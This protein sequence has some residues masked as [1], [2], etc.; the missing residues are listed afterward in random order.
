[1][2]G[3]DSGMP[4]V[5]G[6]PG[7]PRGAAWPSIAA[8]TASAPLR[9]LFAP[10]L[11]LTGVAILAWDYA[12][13]PA[14]P[15]DHV[16]YWLGFGCVYAG[17]VALGALGRPTS[18]RQLVALA[19]LGAVMWLPYYLRSPDRLVFVDELYHRDV[20]ARILDTG[21]AIGLPVTLYPLP[22]NF[23]GLESLTIAVMGATGLGLD[24][25][26]RVVTLAI[27]ATIPC[28]AYLVARGVGLGARGAFVAALVYASN[29]SFAF[30]HSVF[31][32]ETLGVLQFLAVWALVAWYR[33]APADGP[34]P[35]RRR[36]LVLVVAAVP[37]LLAISLTHHVSSYALAITLLVGWVA[38]RVQRSPTAPA[39]R[40]LALLCIVFDTSWFL[41]S[42]DRVGT[43]LGTSLG[44][45]VD[46]IV[47]S[48][49]LDQTSRARCSRTSTSHSSSGCWRSAIRRSCSGWWRSDCGSPGSDR[50]IRRSCCRLP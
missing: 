24:G 28:L 16:L 11:I 33:A 8:W 49:L 12:L 21:H 48:L 17:V 46:T 26:I 6:L 27:H 1:M 7:T 30:F 4:L 25:A 37:L 43:Y 50:I 14:D 40:D 39:V 32:Y 20:A 35:T 45:R 36:R 18:R 44:A 15:L 19:A 10:L 47:D 41:L 42:S 38:L 9:L 34:L 2:T 23:P 29:T 5:A 22:G 13:L 3:T 31:S